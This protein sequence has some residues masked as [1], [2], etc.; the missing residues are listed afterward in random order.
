MTKKADAVAGHW[1]TKMANKMASY[2]SHDVEA[3]EEAGPSPYFH[4]MASVGVPYCPRAWLGRVLSSAE[5]MA[6]SRATRRLAIAGQVERIMQCRRDRVTHLRPTP[7][8][9]ST[10]LALAGDEADRGAIRE[11][12]ARTLW[13]RLL[14]KR[15]RGGTT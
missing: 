3:P 15:L 1:Q 10:A 6:Y 5:R 8:G 14:A 4:A 2:P 7:L 9:L 11:G 13:G 12:L